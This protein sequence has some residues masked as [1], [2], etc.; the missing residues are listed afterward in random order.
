MNKDDHVS[1]ARVMDERNKE[2][3]ALRAENKRLWAEFVPVLYTTSTTKRLGLP[4]CGWASGFLH[5]DVYFTI[6][7]A[8]LGVDIYKHAVDEAGQEHEISL[9]T[10]PAV[11][12][13]GRS[14]PPATA[15]PD[16]EGGEE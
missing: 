7:G 6:D 8:E 11:V 12:A 10:S 9:Y 4:T 2:I 15:F 3:D 1:L 5:V 16:D 14:T 13:L